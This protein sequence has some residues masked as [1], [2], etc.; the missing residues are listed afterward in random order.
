MPDH[1]L[2]QEQP[3]DTP[4]VRVPKGQTPERRAYMKAWHAANPRDRRAYKRAYDEAH[5][6][7][8]RAYYAANRERKS[9]LA[10]ARYQANRQRILARV[11][12]YFEENK[13]RILQYQAEYYAENTGKVK[14]NVAAYQKANPEKHHHFQNRRRARK[15]ENGGSHTLEQRQAKFAGFGNACV[16]CG[17]TERLTID[18]MIPLSRGGTDDIE[19]IVPA[20]RSCNSKKHDK[21]AEEFLEDTGRLL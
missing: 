9:A 7:E 21:T 20:C 1:T 6:E 19:N 10:K 16:Y 13:T 5:K 12:S 3:Q 18:H 11:K 4:S 2:P 15:F 17:T 14:A 8:I